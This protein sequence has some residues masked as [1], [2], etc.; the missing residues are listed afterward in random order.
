MEGTPYKNISGCR[1]EQMINISDVRIAS[2]DP[3]LMAVKD[4]SQSLLLNSTLSQGRNICK[5]RPMYFFNKIETFTRNE[6]P[7]PYLLS[8]S[9]IPPS[10]SALLEAPQKK[11]IIGRIL[12][13]GS[14]T[15]S[16]LKYPSRQFGKYQ[17]RKRLYYTFLLK[18]FH[19][20]FPSLQIQLKPP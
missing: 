1:L 14:L 12:G 16:C 5:T 3:T 13:R 20:R 8:C 6:C 17:A 7:L 18:I 2:L 9:N 10:K 4:R 11:S 15:N 19:V